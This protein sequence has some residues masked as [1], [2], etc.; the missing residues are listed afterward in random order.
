MSNNRQ[1]A[2]YGAAMVFTAGSAFL[3]TF[4]VNGYQWKPA[5]VTGGITF[6][7]M[8]L[9]ALARMG[10]ILNALVGNQTGANK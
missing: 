10:I 3:S 5:L 9:S 4:A 2:L 1:L 8:G 7:A 6:C